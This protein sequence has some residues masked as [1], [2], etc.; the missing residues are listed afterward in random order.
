MRKSSFLFEL[1]VCLDLMQ[2]IPISYRCWPVCCFK[3]GRCY[4]EL[5]H[6]Q[7][8]HAVDVLF[9]LDIVSCLLGRH[10][11]QQHIYQF[12]LWVISSKTVPGVLAFDLAINLTWEFNF[13]LLFKLFLLIANGKKFL[14][15]YERKRVQ[16]ARPVS[17]T[18]CGRHRPCLLHPFLLQEYPF[19]AE[20]QC[21]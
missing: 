2:Y 19:F 15:S 16:K 13:R 20:L 5:G 6:T 9:R 4:V 12:L 7:T 8:S 18:W 3:L 1:N 21:P 10:A 11:V 17:S 14:P